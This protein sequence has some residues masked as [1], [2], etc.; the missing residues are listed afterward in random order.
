MKKLLLAVVV[1]G[2]SSQAMSANWVHV[3]TG[4]SSDTKV[5]VDTTSIRKA[6]A[7]ILGDNSPLYVAW[8]NQEYAPNNTKMRKLGV[9]SAK[10]QYYYSCQH[11]AFYQ[12]SGVGYRADGSV[13]GNFN[14][15]KATLTMN[16]L[17]PVI[18]DSVGEAKLEFVCK[19]VGQ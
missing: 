16:D 12:V 11:R 14:N 9:V 10:S 8:E 5:Y 2:L 3:S 6:S 18:P 17:E 13:V 19:W 4:G 15:N 7:K 1:L